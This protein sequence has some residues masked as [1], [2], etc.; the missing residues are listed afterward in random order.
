MPA[1]TLRE[2]K[3]AATRVQLMNVALRLFEAQGFGNTTVEE[4][5][6][7]AD[8]AP[9][10]FFRYFPTKVDVLFADHPEEIALIRDALAARSPDEAVLD[11]V[12]RAMLEGITKA[13]AD[14]TRFLTR[15]QLVASVPAAHAH[16]RY[17]DSKFEDVIAE[18]VAAD[19]Q[20]DP[21]SDLQAR[22]VARAAWGA[23]CA[24][25]DIWVMSDAKRDPRALVSQ[26]F[27]LLEHNLRP[28]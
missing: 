19:R 25:R 9:R 7:A 8:V 3:K 15:S 5:A 20:T 22:V 4:I 11:A 27:D 16:S 28:K 6:A 10:T 2:R 13:I 23:A 12:K 24:A 21:A 1:A 26:A 17:L 14:P 18:A